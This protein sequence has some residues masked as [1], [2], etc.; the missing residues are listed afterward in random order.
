[1]SYL[2]DAL[3]QSQQAD[4]SAEQYDLQSEQ[5]KQQQA[6]KRYRKIALLLGGS[7]AAFVA[8]AG[9]F[10]SG[11]WLQHSNLLEKPK[12]NEV[13]KVAN[14]LP[15]KE[16]TQEL[17]SSSSE[18]KDKTLAEPSSEPANGNKASI[19]GQ[20]V[21][22]Q[23]PTGVQKMLLTPQ[24]QYIP[25][26]D[27]PQQAQQGYNVQMPINGNAYSQSAFNQPIYNTQAPNTQS[28][29]PLAYNAQGQS[30][31]FMQ[32]QMPN[33]RSAGLD[34]SKY[35]VLGKPL[36]GAQSKPAETP[37]SNPELDAVPSKLKDA[38]AQAIKD[39]EQE[40]EYEVTQASRTSSRVEPVELLPDGL[41]AMLP[42]IK[43]QAHIYSSSA[44]KRW[45]K[46]NG[47]ELYEGES[48]GALTVREITPEQS[49]LDFD[50]Y[51]F[52]LKAL[53]DW[54]Q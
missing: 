21:Y 1:M 53:Q 12:L 54:P 49:V 32:P 37:Q 33:T 2:L 39:S 45:I 22:V 44:D 46:L 20:L 27:N 4:M 16:Q 6:L 17:I 9:G 51:E 24:G 50:G 23:T 13:A 40:Q 14:S 30:A 3:K 15:K 42:S 43:Y 48:I 52:S 29:N 35:K 19:E 36:N 18:P 34:M 41:Q 7:I 11:K 5:L 25:M 31:Q 10:A 26:N 8:V 28:Y 47:R 38:F